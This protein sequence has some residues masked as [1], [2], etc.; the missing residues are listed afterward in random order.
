NRQRNEKAMK[1]VDDVNKAYGTDTV[2]SAVQEFNKDWKLR[3]NFLSSRYTTRWNEL[4]IINA[5]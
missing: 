2:R 5:K 3:A 4:P 1:A